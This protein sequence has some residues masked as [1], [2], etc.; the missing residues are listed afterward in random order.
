MNRNQ[1][2]SMYDILEKL[3][4]VKTDIRISATG[5]FSC[6]A[7]EFDLLA[8]IDEQCEIFCEKLVRVL[9]TPADSKT[10]GDWSTYAEQTL[11]ERDHL[12]QIAT[13]TRSQIKKLS[14]TLFHSN[15]DELQM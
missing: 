3:D 2:E 12:F 9:E 13:I 15:I 10:W 5:L 14:Q 1:A 7:A 4:E 6:P 11:K 8:E